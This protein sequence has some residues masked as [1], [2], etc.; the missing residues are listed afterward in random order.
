MIS[1]RLIVANALG[2]LGYAPIAFAK[3]QHAKLEGLKPYTPNRLEWL[4]T[5]LNAENRVELTESSGYLLT[6]IPI[7][8][9][10]A[11]LLFVRYLPTVD[12]E[13]MN[14]GIATARKV[15]EIAAK[16]RKWT[17]LKVKEDVQ[18]GQPAR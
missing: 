15:I 12:R 4:A 8:N 9:E 6:F 1:R 13:V 18:L 5:E 7:E 17:W 10:D 16:S 14:T 2:V 3:D 11:I